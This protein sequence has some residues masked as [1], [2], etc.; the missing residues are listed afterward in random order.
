MLMSYSLV[1]RNGKPYIRKRHVE[2]FE[3]LHP[4]KAIVRSEF[5]KAASAAYGGIMEDTLDSVSDSMSGKTYKKKKSKRKVTVSEQELEDLSMQAVK[6]G[7]SAEMLSSLI[8]VD[9]I[10]PMNIENVE[11]GGLDISLEKLFLD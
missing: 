7:V 8:T 9:G 2:T 11:P 4:N 3:N 1:V 5:A 6:K 10:E